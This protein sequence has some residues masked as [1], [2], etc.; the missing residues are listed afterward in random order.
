[1]ASTTRRCSAL[2]LVDDRSSRGRRLAVPWVRSVVPASGLLRTRSPFRST[3][4]SGL[5]PTN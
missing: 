4:S 5:A 1:M 3:S 2:S